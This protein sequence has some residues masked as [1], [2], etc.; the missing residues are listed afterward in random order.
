MG[1]GGLPEGITGGGIELRRHEGSESRVRVVD[2]V[3]VCPGLGDMP[4][5]SSVSNGSATWEVMVGAN[6]P[7]LRYAQHGRLSIA[8]GPRVSTSSVSCEESCRLR[9]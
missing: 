1:F 5:Y 6:L 9:R 2:E 4:I 8:G 7:A 3:G